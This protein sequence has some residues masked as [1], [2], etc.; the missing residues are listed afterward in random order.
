MQ[1]LEIKS[2]DK[3]WAIQEV[4]QYFIKRGYKIIDI[5]VL[6][7][8]GFYFYFDRQQTKKFVDEFFAGVELKGIDTKLPLQPKVLVFEQ[9]KRLSWQYH[10]RRAEIWRCI[11]RNCWVMTSDTDMQSSPR[12]IKFGEVVNSTAGMRHRAGSTDGWGAVA[13]IW[14]HTDPSNPSNEEDVVRLQDDYGR[15]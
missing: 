1:L 14:Q 2:E 6:R 7:P 4:G 8:W 12:T 10:G 13:E 11:T 9:G 5:D 15:K 3:L